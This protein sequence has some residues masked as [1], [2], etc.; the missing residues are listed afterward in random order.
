MEYQTKLINLLEEANQ[1]ET[2]QE[3]WDIITTTSKQA[4]HD[5]LGIRKPNKS[6]GNPEI[7]K[8]SNEQKKLQNDINA[9]Q[10]KQ[11]RLAKKEETKKVRKKLNR[12]LTRHETLKIEMQIQDLEKH[13]NDSTKMFKAIRTLQTQEPRKKLVVKGDDGITTDEKV[14]AEKITAYFK[15]V[16]QKDGEQIMTD[17]P[18]TEM[19]TKFTKEEVEKAIV[20][21]KNNKSPGCDG[22][23]AELLKHAPDKLHEHIA[24]LLNTIATTG[25][26]PTEIKRGILIPIPKPGKKQGPPENLRPIILLKDLLQYLF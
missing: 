26:C 14:Q 5:T 17:I 11:T 20:S 23:K 24:M 16:F 25:C 12:A 19:K 8:L 4:G 1:S 7:L 9:C 15:K 10:D 3:I 22:L 6:S 21:L 2:P 18:P 13:K